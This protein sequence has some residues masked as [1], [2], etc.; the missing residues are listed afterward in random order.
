MIESLMG[1]GW[2]D[3]SGPKRGQLRWSAWTDQQQKSD[4]E[5]GDAS[6]QAR[7]EGEA[8]NSKLLP[9]LLATGH[10]DVVDGHRADSVC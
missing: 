4:N 6:W 9:L 7:K 8:Q 1:E 10:D 3:W 2:L 5:T